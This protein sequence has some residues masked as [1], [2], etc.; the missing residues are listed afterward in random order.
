MAH[1]RPDEP[2]SI[3][4]LTFWADA[5]ER[6]IAAASIA[7]LAYM[8]ADAVNNGTFSLRALAVAAATGAGLELARSLAALYRGN[9][10]T[11]HRVR[12]RGLRAQDR[13]WP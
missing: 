3:Y 13:L 10:G 2:T 12:E 8:P 9:P 11:A 7:A 5:L 6:I 4:R 1:A